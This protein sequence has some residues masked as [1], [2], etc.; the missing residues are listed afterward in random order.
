MLEE[1][2]NL[3]KS[4]HKLG[5]NGIA[6][7]LITSLHIASEECNA[8]CTRMYDIAPLWNVCQLV[9]EEGINISCVKHSCYHKSLIFHKLVLQ[10]VF[11]QI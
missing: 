6:H 9:P 2:S 8:R 1:D 3:E 10:L 4:G 5:K 11:S 7:G